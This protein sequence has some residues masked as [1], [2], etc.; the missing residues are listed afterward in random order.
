MQQVAVVMAVFQPD[1]GFLD[2][3]IASIAAQNPVV[4]FA[5]F[6]DADLHSSDLIA[7]LASRHGLQFE[8]VTPTER[9]NPVQA[10]EFGLTRALE[11]CPQTQMFGLCDQD[12]ICVRA[13]PPNANVRIV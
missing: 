1:A 10:F 11:L 3:Q 13:V 4:P 7:R 12:D 9:L 2:A 8:I 5:V 6:V